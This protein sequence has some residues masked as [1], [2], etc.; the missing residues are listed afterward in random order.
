MNASWKGL[1]V[2]ADFSWNYGKGL[3]NNDRFFMEYDSYTQYSRSKD[4]LNRWEK[5]G[6]IA[7]FGK[8]GEAIQFDSHLLEDAS[9]LR[10]KNLTVA[11]EFPKKWMNATGFMQGLRLY[12]TSRNL[13]TFTKYTGFDP[14]ADTNLTYGRYPNSRQFVG[15]I[16]FT[17]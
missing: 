11:Y 15:G 8:F 4:L 5:E 9:F 10:L 14:E 12:F 2:A 6:D 1:S 7:K 3:V 13:L 16:Q 17:F